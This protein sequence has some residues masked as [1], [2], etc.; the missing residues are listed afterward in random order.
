M[1]TIFDSRKKHVGVITA[2]AV[3]LTIAVLTRVIKSDPFSYCGY[4]QH[5]RTEHWKPGNTYPCSF[6]KYVTTSN[7]SDITLYMNTPG[8]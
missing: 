4:C 5:D 3:V 2:V 7:S 6:W 8:G 1:S